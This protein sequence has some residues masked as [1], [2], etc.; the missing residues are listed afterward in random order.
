ME[1][2]FTLGQ[3]SSVVGV[4]WVIYI[5]AYILIAL[6]FDPETP[7]VPQPV[8]PVPQEAPSKQPQPKKAQTKPAEKKKPVKEKNLHK[9]V[10]LGKVAF[11]KF[12]EVYMDDDE[13]LKTHE[14]GKKHQKNSKG[15]DVKWFH[16]TD[17]PQEEL[18]PLPPTAEEVEEGWTL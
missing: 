16:I 2:S 17:K 11:C 13:F 6:Y 1:E 7:Q 15:N 8:K 3:L 5:I 4:V 10:P 14:S 18:K 12:C 9:I